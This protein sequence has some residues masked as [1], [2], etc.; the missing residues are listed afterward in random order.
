MYM[1]EQ[2]VEFI[3]VTAIMKDFVLQRQSTAIYD[4]YNKNKKKQITDN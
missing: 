3:S 1:Y 2:N 4:R